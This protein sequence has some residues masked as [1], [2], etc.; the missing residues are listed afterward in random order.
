MVR[1]AL[2]RNRILADREAETETYIDTSGSKIV[3]H[4]PDTPPI[5]IDSIEELL[6]R[7]L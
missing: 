7:L 4:R 5:A 3:L 2:L 6:Q 1:K